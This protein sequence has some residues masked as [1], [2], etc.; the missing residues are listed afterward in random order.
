MV[1]VGDKFRYRRGRDMDSGNGEA[2]GCGDK[3]GYSKADQLGS[4]RYE[5]PSGSGRR[6]RLTLKE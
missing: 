3:R 2:F 5:L 4:D 1:Y 6:G